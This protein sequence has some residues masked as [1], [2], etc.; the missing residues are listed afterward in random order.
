MI[1]S[2]NAGIDSPASSPERARSGHGFHS[3]QDEREALDSSS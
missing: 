1:S 3:H 2:Q